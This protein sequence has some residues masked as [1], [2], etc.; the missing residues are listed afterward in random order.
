MSF[1]KVVIKYEIP[2]A[3][4]APPTTGGGGE[5]GGGGGGEPPV[6][7]I[8]IVST[9]S[10][11]L[12]PKIPAG[13]GKTPHSFLRDDAAW[14]RIS[15]TDLSGDSPLGFP[16]L[17][18]AASHISGSDLLPLPTLS[19]PGLVPP[20]PT[21]PTLV[22]G[23]G[24]EWIAVGAGGGG[25]GLPPPLNDPSQYL[26]S[27]GAYAPLIQL[28]PGRAGIV[29]A[30]PA[31]VTQ[32]L[33][34]NAKW[35]QLAGLPPAPVNDPTK[36]LRSDNNWVALTP[37]TVG[38]A[39][40][41]SAAPGDASLVLL[42]NAKWGAVPGGGGGGGGG[43]GGTVS[44]DEIT[45]KPSTFPPSTHA[46]SHITGNDL[47]PLTT[48]SAPGLTP[49]L[50]NTGATSKWLRGDASFTAIPLSTTSAPGFLSPLSGNVGDY[51]GGDNT[52]H[53]VPTTATG[54]LPTGSVIDFAGSAAP[55]GWLLCDGSPYSTTGPYAALFAVIQ[56]AYGGSGGIFNVPDFRGR[57]SVGSG[58]G[59]YTG[60][61]NRVLG[62]TGG[63]ENHVQLAAE[64]VSH[65]HGVAHTHTMGNHT[66]TLGNHTHTLG[67]HTHLGVDHLHSMSSHVHGVDH[68]HYCPG[69]DHLHGYDHYH[70]FAGNTG[71]HA[72]GLGGHVHSG[73]YVN[74]FGGNTWGGG[75][76]ISYGGANANT[77][78][79][80]GGSDA[81]Y[82]G[83]NT[84]YASQMGNGWGTSGAM[85]RSAA[86]NSYYAS[87]TSSGWVNSGGPNTNSTGA[88]D[89]GLTT[90]GP[91][92]NTSDGP[93]TNT[94]DAPSTNTT[95]GA[96][97]ANTV[98]TGGGS[99]FNV[100]QPFC[101]VNRI[102]KT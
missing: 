9:A 38:Q 16:P 11:G 25:G 84:I 33:L 18:H 66:H 15:Y 2:P 85:D 45:G 65:T 68:Y 64:L 44:W 31:D 78:G 86:F 67:G 62:G 51:A 94:S 77:G 34:G 53:P 5:G 69:V 43:A 36:F 30:A 93:S 88:A 63:E 99:G 50:P 32:V 72:H 52:F 4:L 46:P 42:G 100:M 41:V 59:S 7:F 14:Q 55:V 89:R 56:Y 47:I 91:S 39:G 35:G 17:P 29:S 98:A 87:Q 71:S 96:S 27:D 70:N 60:A 24:G 90:G 20:L 12:A 6:S 74:I 95:D 58:Q 37:L 75:S 10:E 23:G 76:G 81:A 57:V 21:D 73:Y 92:T 82:V 54:L 26:R 49:A 19:S 101:V 61:T 40:I 3:P 22:L 83:G 13:S 79:P 102:I 97:I 48:V 8:P 80:S 1:P 28:A